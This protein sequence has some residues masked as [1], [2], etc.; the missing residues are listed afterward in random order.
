M[1]PMSA[2][3]D[4]ASRETAAPASPTRRPGFVGS[5]T[6]RE[7]TIL[8]MI[9]GGAT[10]RETATALGISPRTVEFHRANI[11][12]KSAARNLAELMLMMLGGSITS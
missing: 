3:L 12:Q 10:N 9:I 8:S 2:V 6:A 5:L 11:M 7:V 4:P 1:A